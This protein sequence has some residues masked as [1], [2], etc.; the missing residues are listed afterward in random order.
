M[1]LNSFY[2]LHLHLST[3]S[4]TFYNVSFSFTNNTSLDYRHF[5]VEV[6]VFLPCPPSSKLLLRLLLLL[7]RALPNSEPVYLYFDLSCFQWIFSKRDL[8]PRSSMPHLSIISLSQFFLI[9]CKL[10]SY[11]F[12]P[13]CQCI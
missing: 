5:M 2:F 11:P 10:A 3:T 12:S 8:L 1:Q 9:I 6:K 7:G 13:F 4:N